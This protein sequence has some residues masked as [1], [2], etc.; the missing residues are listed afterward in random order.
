MAK[1]LISRGVCAVWLALALCL[2]FLNRT[3][4]AAPQTAS[5]DKPVEQAR[6]N[7]QV[8]RGLPGGGRGEA[9]LHHQDF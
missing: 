8:L 1:L 7:I 5:D 9:A 4:G 2:L 6:K 3:S